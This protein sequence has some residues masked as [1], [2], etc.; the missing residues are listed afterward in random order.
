MGVSYNREALVKTSVLFVAAVSFVCGALA[1][2]VPAFAEDVSA[3]T[4]VKDKILNC[5]HP[6]TNAAKAT[7]E[8]QA[9]KTDGETTT[10]RV[11][12]F[13]E[14]LIKKNSLEMD[15]LVRASGSIRQFKAN[16]LSDTSISIKPC[17]M[18]K[19]WTDF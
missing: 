9:P 6:T 11:K 19:T 1:A 15:V 14:G 12:V 2:G 8:A 16:V 3:T 17:D 5:L 7:I 18:T 4:L 10:T 13:Y